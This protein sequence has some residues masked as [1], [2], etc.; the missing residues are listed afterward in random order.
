MSNLHTH[1][2]F[3]V[4]K[5]SL[6]Y[7]QKRIIENLSLSIKAGQITVLLGANG[8]GKSTLL[9]GLARLL[10]P[11]E[12]RVLLQ[13]K[14]IAEQDT[15]E[16]AKQLGVLPQSPSAFEGITVTELVSLGRYPHQSLF[17]QWSSQDQQALETALAQTNLTEFA[18]T[19][20]DQMSGGQRQRAWIAMTLAQQTPTILLD[21]PTT[22]LD[23][24]HQIDILNLL[25]KLNREHGRNIIM[26]LH[27]IDLAC[28][29]AHQL[30]LIK[31]GKVV[32]SGPPK[33]VITA[34][35]MKDVFG[36]DCDIYPDPITQTPKVIPH[37][38]C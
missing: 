20:V 15:K 9:K 19:G 2:V 3:E 23:L 1:S 29:Y 7:D 10:T 34:Q 12:G 36:L 22:Y 35:R 8:C 33:D 30:V 13:G 21:E 16:I 31:E 38:S 17:Q 25:R 11:Q 18:D 37:E 26:V 6:G 4:E 28:R 5:L 27:D 14:A 24:S 32:V